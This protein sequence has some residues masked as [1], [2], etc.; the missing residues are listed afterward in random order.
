MPVVVFSVASKTILLI[1]SI[2][3][4]AGIV[5]GK[6]S[7]L[8]YFVISVCTFALVAD[9]HSKIR[10]QA[11]STIIIRLGTRIARE[12]TLITHRV[13]SVKEALIANTTITQGNALESIIISAERALTSR[14]T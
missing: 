10:S 2:A 1:A 11:R 9:L 5:A 12:V 14:G 13:S 8:S 3:A 7:C 4:R 6:A